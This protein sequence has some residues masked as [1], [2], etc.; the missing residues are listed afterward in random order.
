MDK[1]IFDSGSRP[2]ASAGGA[3]YANVSEYKAA[4]SPGP[5]FDLVALLAP[6]APHFA[7]FVLPT[8]YA[9]KIK[10]TVR[11]IMAPETCRN[12]SPSP[13]GEPWGSFSINKN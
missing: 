13:P 2:L 4:A 1:L 9:K 10:K 6:S 3:V 11:Q 12:G 5:F 8:R 7:D